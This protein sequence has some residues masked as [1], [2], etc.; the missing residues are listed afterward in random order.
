MSDLEKVKKHDRG[1]ILVFTVIIMVVL[2]GIAALAVDIGQMYVA[3]Q[4][5]Q[6][7]CDAAALAG[8]QKLAVEAR[9]MNSDS[10]HFVSTSAAEEAAEQSA[11][12][13]NDV[14][15]SW[16]IVNPEGETPGIKVTF[17]VEGETVLWDSGKPE[18]VQYT[19]QAIRVDG[20]VNVETA[21]AGIFGMYNKLIPAHAT[22]IVNSGLCSPLMIPLTGSKLTISGDGTM[23]PVQSQVLYTLHAGS[24]TAGELGPGNYLMLAFPGDTGK[25]DYGKRLAGAGDVCL[26]KGSVVDASSEP[27]D[28]ANQTYKGLIDRFNKETDSRF[29]YDEADPITKG[30]SAWQAWLADGAA[31]GVYPDTQRLVIIPLIQETTIAGRKSVTIAG[32]AGFFIRNIYQKS[33]TDVEGDHEA[34]DVRGYFVWGTVI[35]GEVEWYVAPGG[36]V[37]ETPEL[38]VTPRLIS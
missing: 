31:D 17:P 12:S 35:G 33:T 22:A 21:F 15:P 3:K 7:V 10:S 16:Q 24:W 29:T 25:A 19:G 11:S 27:G 38:V 1:A 2:I 18:T 5:A 37:P 9:M 23:P 6:N 13:N 30:E 4:R 14:V 36:T 28:A 32:F 34:G 20:E 8:V 26:S